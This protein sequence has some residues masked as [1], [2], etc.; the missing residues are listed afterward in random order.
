MRWSKGQGDY[1][2][3][4][5]GWEEAQKRQ[6]VLCAQETERIPIVPGREAK[7]KNIAGN[8]GRKVLWGYIIYSTNVYVDMI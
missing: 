2:E 5:P 1:L 8:V 7:K 4:F 3:G 6:S